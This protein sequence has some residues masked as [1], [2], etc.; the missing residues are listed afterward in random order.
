M[1][2]VP[3][4]TIELL[5]YLLPGF[6]ASWVFYGLTSHLKPSQFERVVEALIFSLIIKT[7]AVPT[8][9][10]LLLIG[11]VF[12]LSSWNS[13]SELITSVFLAIFVGFLLSYLNIKGSIYRLFSS[14]G[15][16]KTSDPSEWYGTLSKHE[17]YVVLHFKDEKRLLGYP[18]V[19]PSD[20]EKGHFYIMQPAWLNADDSTVD[21][22][23]CNGLLINTTDVRWVEL[24][25][26][27]T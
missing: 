8:K 12:A 9:F 19:W 10:F 6:L 25:K 22:E 2:D 11:N 7:T 24:V 3:N 15:F 21:L 18:K 4:E 13:S 17:W 5:Q 23:G 14:F 16:T 1:P 26:R 27:E 20:A